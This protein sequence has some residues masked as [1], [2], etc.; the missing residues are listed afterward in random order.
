MVVTFE[1]CLGLVAVGSLW[2][3]VVVSNMSRFGVHQTQLAART[4][5]KRRIAG[6][7]LALWI[8]NLSI[9]RCLSQKSNKM[10][11]RN[12]SKRRWIGWIV[13]ELCFFRLATAFFSCFG[14][15]SRYRAPL[16]GEN[17]AVNQCCGFLLNRPNQVRVD[18]SLFWLCRQH[19]YMPLLVSPV[20]GTSP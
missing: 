15:L 1:S 3:L 12:T 14:S 20:S 2:I 7:Q 13:F 10:N 9:S 6:H 5:G 16:Y 18:A 17:V 19:T 11:R 4:G 8:L